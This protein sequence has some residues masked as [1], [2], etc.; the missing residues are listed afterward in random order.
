MLFVRFNASLGKAKPVTIKALSDSGASDKTVNKKFAK[1]LRV[2][3]LK[4]PARC[5]PHL[6]EM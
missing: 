5:G 4:V 6:Q 1:K 3:T 2:K